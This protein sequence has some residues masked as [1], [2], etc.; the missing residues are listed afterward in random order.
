[1]RFEQHDFEDEAFFAV[2]ILNSANPIMLGG[3]GVDEAIHMAA[4]PR[5]LEECRK[6][7][8]T[9]GIR[10]PFGE[11]RITTAGNLNCKYVIHT[12]GPIYDRE[13]GSAQVLKN[14][15]I[16]SLNL[17]LENNCSS[18]AFTAI[19]C[20]AY[21]YPPDEAAEISLAVCNQDMYKDL[22]I[23]FYL[24]GREIVEIWQA[25]FSDLSE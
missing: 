1:M 19:S 20:G 2:S 22:Q 17:A 5:L 9:N 14:S 25:E 15:Y 10:C 18:I 3:G 11:A 7:K 12:A 21:G 23:I 24:F 16:N 4:G 6:V 8:S 13:R